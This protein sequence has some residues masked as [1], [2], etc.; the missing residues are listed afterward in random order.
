MIIQKEDPLQEDAPPSYDEVGGAPP[1]TSSRPTDIKTPIGTSSGGSSSTTYPPITPN[2]RGPGTGTATLRTGKETTGSWWGLSFV[3]SRKSREVRTTVLGIIRDVV[4]RTVDD[5]VE[6]K[7]ILESCHA[8]CADDRIPFNALLQEKSIEGYSAIYWAIINRKPA[9]DSTSPD[10]LTLVLSY[11]A[12]LTPATVE[13]IKLACLITSDQALFQR[14]RTSAEFIAL[15]GTDEMVLGGK[16]A[17]DAVEVVEIPSDE[18]AFVV[19]IKLM[20][21][22]KRMRV[23][24]EVGVDFIAR[25]RMWRLAFCISTD[26]WRHD[27]PRF[28]AWYVS[29]T[30]LENSPPTWVDSRLLIPDAS[31]TIPKP[32]SSSLADV[33]P[34]RSNDGSR[35]KPTISIRLASRVELGPRQKFG[36]PHHQY[37][38]YSLLESDSNATSLQYSGSSYIGSNDS[39]RIRLEGKLGKP[40]DECVIC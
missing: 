14:L 27:R 9:S 39:L 38:V 2:L 12:P 19:D 40:Q 5:G 33:R 21:F 13:E 26:K 25:G 7:G 34:P 35:L 3:G 4:R 16:A 28:G 36:H 18:G 15:S 31:L 37:N 1:S 20:K 10:L 6:A 30:L 23:S 11:A 17:P 22:Q 24:G 29:L 8:A 32:G